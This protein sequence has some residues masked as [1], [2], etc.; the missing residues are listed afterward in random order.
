MTFTLLV[1]LWGSQRNW[2]VLSV[3]LFCSV[4]QLTKPFFLEGLLQ[5]QILSTSAMFL[6]FYPWVIKWVNLYPSELWHSLILSG[7]RMPANICLWLFRTNQC[8]RHRGGAWSGFPNSMFH[9]HWGCT[10]WS[11]RWRPHGVVAQS[12][13]CSRGRWRCVCL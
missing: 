2:Y 5:E 9:L 1:T 11:S 10:S 3:L 6:H 13:F 12:A 8:S 7:S 4:R